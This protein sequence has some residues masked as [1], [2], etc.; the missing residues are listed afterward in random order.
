VAEDIVASG[1]SG[2]STDETT[3]TDTPFAIRLHQF[4]LLT[5][6]SDG[7]GR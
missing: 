7:K 3:E 1:D 5:K 6:S 2:L 4:D